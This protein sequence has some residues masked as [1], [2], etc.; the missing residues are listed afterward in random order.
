MWICLYLFCFWF[1]ILAETV[2]FHLSLFW[3]RLLD[4]TYSN[5]MSTLSSVTFLLSLHF[6]PFFPHCPLVS[7]YFINL[8]AS[9]IILTSSVFNPLFY[10]SLELLISVVCF[11]S[12]ILFFLWIHILFLKPLYFYCFIEYV[13]PVIWFW[14]IKNPW[15]RKLRT[16]HWMRLL[17]YP[18][19]KFISYLYFVTFALVLC[20]L[21]FRCMCMCVSVHYYVLFCWI[22]F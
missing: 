19:H 18:S 8:Y 14:I 1:T 13:T 20:V 6:T 17:L 22:F 15:Y 5:I 12:V 21:V 4:I 9:L 10:T 11:T 16:L 3:G 7:I 2:A